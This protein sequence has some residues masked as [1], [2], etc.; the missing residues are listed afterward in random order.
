MGKVKYNYVWYPGARG[1]RD[2][3]VLSI[4]RQFDKETQTVTFGWALNVPPRWVPLTNS[5]FIGETLLPG[6]HF[7]RKEG[8][9]LAEGR[10]ATKPMG[11]LVQ[12][13]KLPIQMVFEHISKSPLYP[14][15]AR[16]IAKDELNR[17][18]LTRKS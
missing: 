2:A 18:W 13:G 14:E 5:K 10:L 8:R 3:Y 7:S 11:M 9:R 4:A 17:S 1:T 15:I 6:D 12:E 16:E